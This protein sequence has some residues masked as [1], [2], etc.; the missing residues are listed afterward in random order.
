MG[1]ILVVL[2]LALLFAGA[3]FA[4]HMLWIVAAVIAVF[5]LIGFAFNGGGTTR[6]YR[7]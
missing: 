2:L 5:W 7:W 6:W 1:V 4:A 3:G